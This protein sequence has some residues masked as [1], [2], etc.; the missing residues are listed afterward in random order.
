MGNSTWTGRSQPFANA[1]FGKSYNKS[2]VCDD[3]AVATHT[4]GSV[5]IDLRN[6][7]GPLVSLAIVLLLYH[8]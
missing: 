5:C 2:L 7:Q 1:L 4:F 8:T 3:E 6:K